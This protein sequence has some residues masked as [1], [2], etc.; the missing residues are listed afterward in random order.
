[1]LAGAPTQALLTA[2]SRRLFSFTDDL[3]FV[4]LRR[5]HFAS[6]ETAMDAR[7]PFSQAPNYIHD[8]I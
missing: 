5:V 8:S 4:D 6:V 7:R 1:M 2:I 3:L